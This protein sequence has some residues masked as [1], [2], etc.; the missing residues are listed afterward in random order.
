MS[1]L[2]DDGPVYLSRVLLRPRGMHGPDSLRDA[3]ALHQA[4][5]RAFPGWSAEDGGDGARRRGP[6][7]ATL[8]G[9][10]FLWR[11][12]RLRDDA[13]EVRIKLLVQSRVEPDWSHLGDLIDAYDPPQ[14]RALRWAVSVG[15]VHRFYLRANPTRARKDD[16]QPLAVGDART[17]FG[18][19]SKAERHE[20]RGK[21]VAIWSAEDRAAWLVRKLEAAGGRVVTRS[22][23]DEADD[24]DVRSVDVA[25]VRTS[26]S[27]PWRWQRPGDKTQ[28]THDGVDFE[29]MLEVVDPDALRR[30]LTLG[31]G[32]A[33]SMG[34]GLLSLAPFP[35]VAP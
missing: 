25:A 26:A 9:A 16:K 35:G 33:K 27:R 20:R 30:A 19:L 22:M 21:R 11:G 28:G 24:G 18:A 12:D 8:D 3:Y 1:A 2:I 7:G 17:T 6:G 34:F 10:V 32:S 13:G 23:R 31:V 15:A 14:A 5:W 29:G 4:L